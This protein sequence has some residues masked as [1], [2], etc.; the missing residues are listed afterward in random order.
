MTLARQFA[1][2]LIVLLA[3]ATLLS[4]AMGEWLNAAAIGVT[5]VFSGMF[6]FLNEYRSEREIAALHRLSPGEPK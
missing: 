2:K 6:G 4:L 5:V 1:S 3:G